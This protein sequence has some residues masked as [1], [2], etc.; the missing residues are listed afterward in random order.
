[1]GLFD[2]FKIKPTISSSNENK[3]LESQNSKPTES[4]ISLSE[5][6]YMIE[7]EV[8]VGDFGGAKPSLTLMKSG[9]V[10]LIVETPPFYDGN[11]NAIYGD[12]DFPEG[13]EFENLIA[14]YVGTPV[15]RE[16]RELFIIEK[17]KSD[18]LIKVKEFIENYWSLRKDIYKKQ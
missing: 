13:V 10:Y 9:K 5:L 1:M 8:E 14:E 15:E 2:F 6:D 11:G 18:T 3:K 12:E 16:D 17:P 7:T 4:E